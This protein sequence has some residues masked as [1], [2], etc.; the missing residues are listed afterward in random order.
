MFLPWIDRYAIGDELVDG[1]HRR[2]LEMINLLHSALVN[3]G[4]SEVVSQVITQVAEYSREHFLAEEAL[5]DRVSY[6]GL[7]AHRK[8]H[9]AMIKQLTMLLHR[10]KRGEEISTREMLAFLKSWWQEHIMTEDR[11]IGQ[12]IKERCKS[13]VGV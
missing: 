5:M 10:M 1:Q 6:P 2:M 4:A 7:V 11:K 13:P 3:K 12:W 9:G 8:H